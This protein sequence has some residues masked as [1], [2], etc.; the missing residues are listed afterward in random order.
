MLFVKYSD[1]AEH[2]LRSQIERE[3]RPRSTRQWHHLE[4]D[5]ANYIF[6]ETQQMVYLISKK[7]I[8]VIMTVQIFFAL[9]YYCKK[10][11]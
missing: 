7:K 4:G 6:T 5:V 8:A 9:S 3:T 2:E 10:Y 1:S 11:V